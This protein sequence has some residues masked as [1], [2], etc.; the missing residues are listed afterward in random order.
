M[1][2]EIQE[3]RESQFVLMYG[4]GAL[5][6]S[7]NGTRLIPEINHCFGSR[8]YNADF[9]KKNEF[10]NEIRMSS[11]I[12]SITDESK[13]H[14]FS[15][16]SN[17]SQ[18]IEKGNGSYNTYVFPTWKICNDKHDGIGTILYDSFHSK[19]NKCPICGEDPSTNVRFVLACCDGH[20]D[21]IL[22]DYAIHGSNNSCSPK[23]YFWKDRGSSFSDIEIKCPDCGA[24]KTMDE[25]YLDVPF[26]CSGRYPEKQG[27]LFDK[28]SES[29]ALF[30]NFADDSK[31]SK[32][33]HYMK[34]VQKQST[35]LRVPNTI[36]LLKMPKYD[37]PIVKLFDQQS[38]KFLKSL[39]AASTDFVALLNLFQDIEKDDLK[40]LTNYLLEKKFIFENNGKYVNS[41]DENNNQHFQE[42]KKLILDIINGVDFKGALNEELYTLNMDEISESSMVKRSF[43]NYDLKWLDNEFPIKI[44]PI[45]KLKTV[46]AQLSYR[47][48]PWLDSDDEEPGNIKNENVSSGHKNEDGVWYPAYE[49]VGEGIFI[50]SD[51]NPLKYMNLDND[52]IEKWGNVIGHI[53]VGDRDE[54]KVP[55]FVW[56]HTLSHA[57]INSL[58]LSCG[59]NSTS[60][61]ERIYIN[62]DNAGILIYNTSPGEDSGMG[63]LVETVNSF[64]IVLKNAMNTLLFCSNDPLCYNE[65]IG[66]NK[67]NGAACHNCLLISETSCEHRNTLLDRHLFI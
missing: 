33:E 30:S 15:M 40:T 3:I 11:V 23:Y 55:L 9:L 50:T 27:P 47:R 39:I 53:D 25:I 12:K 21:D 32:C 16:P 43:I 61:K 19:N 29:N 38:F 5:I 62:G 66:N 13:I 41:D 22:W 36:T 65:E 37:D 8:R 63:G 48:E 64:D 44:S 34:I 26:K 49:G 54:I 57:L 42:F 17:S 7:K 10:D 24:T 4:P 52:V 67:V 20:L 2:R 31:K 6:E 51:Y 14:L 35:S 60:L 46:T 28:T 58:S 18:N 56:W 45:S 1:V 59:Y